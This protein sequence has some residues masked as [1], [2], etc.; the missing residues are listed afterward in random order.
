MKR[1]LISGYLGFENFGDEAL[2]FVLINNLTQIGYKREDITVISNNPQLTSTAFNVNSINRWNLI[3]FVKALSNHDSLIFTGGVFQD[4]TSFRSL[5]YYASQIIL[6]GLFQNKIAFFACGIGPIKRKISKRLFDFAIKSVNMIT[7]RDDVSASI[8]G[9]RGSTIVT[10]DPV[11]TLKPDFNFK[12][13]LPR[14]N[15]GLPILGVSIRNDKNLKGNF[16]LNIVEKLSKI[17]TSMKDWQ[18]VLI[19]CMP[20][21]LQVLYHVQELISRKSSL[22]NRV[23]TIDNFA[24]F[25]VAEQ[26]GILA[27]CEVMVGM[28]YHALLVPLANGKPVFGLIYDQK[29]K[30]LLDFSSQVGVSFKDSFEQPWSYFWQNLER[31]SNLAKQAAERGSELHKINLQLLEALYQNT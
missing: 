21:D 3:E 7:V 30:S 22:P 9:N 17:L 18:I 13:K 31:S 28:R 14:I 1:I 23:F 27:S 26:A 4:R 12:T 15:W 8:I 25:P 10:C 2:L 5:F 24:E 6:A 29:V 19:P 16:M 20:E 11:W